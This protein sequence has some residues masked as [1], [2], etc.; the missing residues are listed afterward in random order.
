MRPRILLVDHHDSFTYNLY[1]LLSELG[2]VVEVLQSDALEHAGAESLDAALLGPG[3]GEPDAA[4][5]TLA[6]IERC[7]GALPVLGVCLGHQALARAFGA[8][9]RRARAPLHGKVSALIH[10]GQ[11][12]FAGVPQGCLVARYNSLVVAPETLPAELR[13]TARSPEGEVM[14]LEHASLPLWGVQFHP[15]SFLSEH[16]RP[17]MQNWLRLLP[18]RGPR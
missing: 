7:A 10:D 1:Q 15:E 4:R 17:M 18:A 5:G 11:G 16:G 14:A 9:V 13:V 8:D 12:L 3:H 6:L 2:A